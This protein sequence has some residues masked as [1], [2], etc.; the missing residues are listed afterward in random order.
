[1]PKRTEIGKLQ[2]RNDASS[3]D[4][5]VLIEKLLNADRKIKYCTN[6]INQGLQKTRNILVQR[7][8]GELIFFVEDDL[9][10]DP[11]C[12]AILVDTLSSISA[13]NER[14]GAIAPSLELA[15]ESKNVPQ[16]AVKA[17]FWNGAKSYRSSETK[18]SG[19]VFMEQCG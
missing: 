4:T 7:S 17:I 1:M 2:I 3:D 8:Q 10:L 13:Q 9:V 5:I 6:E 14:V 15:D 12:L 11:N 16:R 18:S 19:R